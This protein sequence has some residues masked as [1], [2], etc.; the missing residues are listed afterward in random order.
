MRD[1]AAMVV[2]GREM[3][4]ERAMTMS[5]RLKLDVRD[6]TGAA[7]DIL[8]Q[9]QE[10]GLEYPVID[11]AHDTLGDLVSSLEVFGRDVLPE[12]A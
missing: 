2:R 6:G 11:L 7:I 4:G 10:A 1:Y 9:L 8:G 3:A 5:L 12:F